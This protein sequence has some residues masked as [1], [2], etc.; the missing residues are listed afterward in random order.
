MPCPRSGSRPRRWRSSKTSSKPTERGPHDRIGRAVAADP[1]VVGG[2]FPRQFRHPHDVAVAQ[3]RLPQAR[4]RR[5]GDGRAAGVRD[6]TGRLLRPA[7]LRPGGDALTPVR[8]E[9]EE[10]TS[11]GND[12]VPERPAAHGQAARGLVS[13]LGGRGTLRRVHRGAGPAPRCGLPPSAL[14]RGRHGVRR[15]RAGAVADVDLVRPRLARDDQGHGGFG[16]LRPGHGR[17][18]RMDVAALSSGGHMAHTGSS[19]SAVVVVSVLASTSAPAQGVRFGLLAGTTDLTAGG[20]S[21]TALTFADDGPY[22]AGVQFGDKGAGA[23]M[24]LF[25][26]QDR[27]PITVTAYEYLS[28][29]VG[30]RFGAHLGGVTGRDATA[31]AHR[32]QRVDAGVEVVLGPAH[33]DAR[34]RKRQR[35]WFV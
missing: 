32:F 31:V 19:L 25:W 2:G 3:E 6:P 13:L 33:R 21:V 22:A 14:L 30:Y 15:L 27:A 4:Q 20:W 18:P 10:G 11:G 7:A 24:E 8:R 9:D 23:M 16:D 35:A 1:A 12:G 5:Q 29:G 28:V 34:D 26:Q 17:H